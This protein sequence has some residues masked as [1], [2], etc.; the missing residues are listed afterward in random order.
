MKS[1]LSESAI[2][3]GGGEVER[4]ADV[5]AKRSFAFDHVQLVSLGAG[6]N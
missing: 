3:P 2:I 1:L 4:Y 6:S 5:E